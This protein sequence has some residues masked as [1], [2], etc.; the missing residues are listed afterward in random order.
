M[1]SVKLDQTNKHTSSKFPKLYKCL[2]ETFLLDTDSHKFLELTQIFSIPIFYQILFM[3]TLIKSLLI[4]IFFIFVINNVSNLVLT[5]VLLELTISFLLTQ[6]HVIVRINNYKVK[7]FADSTFLEKILKFCFILIFCLEQN[8]TIYYYDCLMFNLNPGY[9]FFIVLLIYFF[10]LKSSR[11]FNEYLFYSYIFNLV[12][13]I[14]FC[15]FR[16]FMNFFLPS[17]L[18]LLMFILLNLI[19]QSYHKKLLKLMIYHKF[20]E[21]LVQTIFKLNKD[22]MMITFDN[23]I[24]YTENSGET[25]QG[26]QVM[27]EN[28]DLIKDLDSNLKLTQFQLCDQEK[29]DKIIINEFKGFEFVFKNSKFEIDNKL[30]YFTN[31]LN[32]LRS[33]GNF[34]KEVDKEFLID[35]EQIFEQSKSYIKTPSLKMLMEKIAD[36]KLRERIITLIIAFLIEAGF[37]EFKTTKHDII[38]NVSIEQHN[39]FEFV[40]DVNHK[41]EKINEYIITNIRELGNS[42]NFNFNFTD[43]MD[44]S[45]HQKTKVQIRFDVLNSLH[46]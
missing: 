40:M 21:N 30:F 31:L 39:R 2:K 36:F 14:Y 4:G 46:K 27:N 44:G 16:N 37:H 32:Y 20:F 35:L 45:N 25:F 9:I 41:N 10:D 33:S 1:N 5:L 42:L 12:I 29:V 7:K 19:S 38:N 23:R 8:Y 17:N 6:Q 22:N 13:F 26:N 24:L 34:I 18:V 11:K 43:A 28:N 15:S 3:F